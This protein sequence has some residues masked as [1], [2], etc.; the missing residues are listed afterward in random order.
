[1]EIE[2]VNF[3]EALI[4]FFE[5]ETKTGNPSLDNANRNV[6]NSL[7]RLYKIVNTDVPFSPVKHTVHLGHVF[8]PF[9][10]KIK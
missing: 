1:M 5:Q 9:G 6:V 8:G 7:S 4:K 2:M 3:I 10:F